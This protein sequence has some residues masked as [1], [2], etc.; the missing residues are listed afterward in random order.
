MYYH[1]PTLSVN[2][3]NKI[4]SRVKN[5]YYPSASEFSREMNILK[6]KYLCQK[7]C[8]DKMMINPVYL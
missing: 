5:T 8:K 2:A 4:L 1:I 6:H 7:V 3:D